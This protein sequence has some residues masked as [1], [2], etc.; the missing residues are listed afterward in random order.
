A[1]ALI[2]H[3]LNEA[4]IEREAID[5]IALGLG[6]GSYAGIRAAIALA[7]GWQLACGVRL[8]GVSTVEGLATQAM[9]AGVVGSAHVV[10]DAQ[11][12]EFYLASYELLQG[13]CRLTHPLQLV[14]EAEIRERT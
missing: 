2:Q 13:D 3:A 1:L 9:A 12:R 5:T 10:I 7:Q 8:L 14:T 4:G 11:R 6:P